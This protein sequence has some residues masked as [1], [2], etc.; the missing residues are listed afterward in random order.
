MSICKS[1]KK[2]RKKKSILSSLCLFC[3]S[4]SLSP[5]GFKESYSTSLLQNRPQRQH[6]MLFLLLNLC[7]AIVCPPSWAPSLSPP[8]SASL[9]RS[10]AAQDE[11]ASMCPCSSSLSG[12][13]WWSSSSFSN[14]APTAGWN[15]SSP[16]KLSP[17]FLNKCGC[18]NRGVLL[19]HLY[20][21]VW[22]SVC[23]VC[24]A[25]RRAE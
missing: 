21:A 14:W 18:S 23:S 5:A 12:A 13:P 8:H 4:A 6:S 3:L 24:W 9:P 17:L 15:Y 19:I 1:H 7:S 11:S 16:P 22:R 10:P 20:R 25:R 2:K